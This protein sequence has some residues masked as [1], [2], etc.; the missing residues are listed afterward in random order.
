[1]DST[2]GACCNDQND[3]GTTVGIEEP[4]RGRDGDST[5]KCNDGNPAVPVSVSHQAGDRRLIMGHAVVH[6]FGA[7]SHVNDEYGVIVGD[8]NDE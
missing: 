7:D 2:S 4:L 5:V 3:E 1:M 6:I 8:L